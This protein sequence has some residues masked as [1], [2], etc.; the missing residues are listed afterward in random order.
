M[1]VGL[2]IGGNFARLNSIE[3]GYYFYYFPDGVQIMMPNQPVP[4]ENP[5]QS[6]F[7]YET[8]PEG[9]PQEGELVM[10][11]FFDAQTFFGSPQI[12]F[13]FGWLW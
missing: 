4:A 6:Q 12:T 3:F 9:H 5:Q 7:P 11:P 10:Q 1:K 13:T 8:Y 2:D